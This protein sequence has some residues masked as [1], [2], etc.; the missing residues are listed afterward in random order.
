MSHLRPGVCRVN[1]GMS[2]EY[3]PFQILFLVKRQL[4]MAFRDISRV[5]FGA[6]FHVHTLWLFI[7]S[8]IKT[9]VGPN[10]V[11]AAFFARLDPTMTF[12]GFIERLPWTL[13]WLIINLVAFTINNQRREEAIAEDARNKPWRP[14]PSGRISQTTAYKLGACSII[15]AVFSGRFLGGGSMESLV[16]I[17]LGHLYNNTSLGTRHWLVRN[18]LNAGGFCAFAAGALSVA[19]QDAVPGTTYRWLG[20]LAAVIVT[21]IHMQ[22]IPDQDGDRAAGRKTFP[23]VFGDEV[24]RRT[25]AVAM[26]LW[27]I[28]VLLGLKGWSP[29]R[30]LFCGLGFCVASRLLTRKDVAEDRFSFLLYNA[31]IVSIYPLSLPPHTHGLPVVMK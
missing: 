6:A 28:G 2:N 26:S 17:F 23:L 4:P 18:I 25:I 14:L 30:M 13:T 9:M 7:A 15:L 24:A 8:D 16:L 21:T 29:A 1:S 31:W 10:I 3:P 5:A 20:F 19:L 11:F 27:S 12:Q 22:D